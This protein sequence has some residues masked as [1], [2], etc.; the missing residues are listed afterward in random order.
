MFLMDANFRSSEVCLIGEIPREGGFALLEV[1][2]AIVIAALGLLGLV[3]L[4]AKSIEMETE[5]YQR[6]QALILL[7][8]MVNRIQSNPILAGCLDMNG[9]YVGTSAGGQYFT[10]AG[11]CGLSPALQEGLA[12]WDQM[13]TG[14]GEVD[15][16]NTKIGAM[17]G[18]RGCIEQDAGTPLIYTVAIAWQGLTPQRLPTVGAGSPAGLQL[19]VQC[20]KNLYGD[21]ETGGVS[22][23]RVVWLTIGP[24]KQN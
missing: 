22:R 12:S 6:T 21:N 9:Q 8:E 7:E 16:G 13:L 11:K 15:S 20:G 5:S 19:A 1:L 23:R 3:G 4:Q 10:P 24:A 14:A 2:V 17:I 18:A